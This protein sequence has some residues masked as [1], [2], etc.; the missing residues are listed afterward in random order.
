MS[1]WREVQ[2]TLYSRWRDQWAVAPGAVPL[3]QLTPYWFEDEKAEPV[4]AP[5][6]RFSVKRMPG[7]PGTM[8]RPGNRKM[9]RV[10]MV[11]VQLFQPPLRGIGGLSDLGERAAAIFENCR[12]IE[13]RDI[14]FGEVEPGASGQIEA[15]RWLG[16]SVEGRFDYEDIR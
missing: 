13:T 10:G 12:L 11:F 14:R 2:E 3:V 7:G 9:D 8:G 1:I 6:A 15:G 5:W 4:D 16:L